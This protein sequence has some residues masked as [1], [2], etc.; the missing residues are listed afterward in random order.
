MRSANPWDWV[1]R[2][3]ESLRRHEE[4]RQETRKSLP[5]YEIIEELGRGGMAVVYR[6]WDPELGRQIAL[7][8]LQQ[9]LGA[10]P[11]MRERFLREAQMVSRL[12]H[13]HI[14]TVYDTGEWDG[15]GYLAMRLVEGTT[16]DRAE[17]DLRR[18][19][20]A[21]R[22]AAR[23][24]DHAHRQGIVH[25]DVKPSNFLVDR[26]GQV[27]VSDFGVARRIDLP[28]R[29]T[30]TGVAVGT[31]A[32]ISPEQAQGRDVDPRSDVYSLGAAMYEILCGQP[33]FSGADALK[34]MAARLSA[35]PVPPSRR[36]AGLSRA[37][38]KIVQ[39]A[40]EREPAHRYASAAD[41]ADDIQRFLDGEPIR[42]RPAPLWFRAR[43]FLVRH[44]WRLVAA[45]SLL[46]L[47]L[48]AARIFLAKPAQMK[49]SL[50]DRSRKAIEETM[51]EFSATLEREDFETAREILG[52]MR[53]LDP[54]GTAPFE[55]NLRKRELDLYKRDFTAAL[56]AG[57]FERARAILESIRRLDLNELSPL[58]QAFSLSKLET[59]KG[60]FQASMGREDWDGA[61]RILVTI[62]GLNPREAA[63][64]RRELRARQFDE[65]S[66][67][68]GEY[69]N[70][71]DVV[72]FEQIHASLSGPEFD[73]SRIRDLAWHLA[74]G[75]YLRDQHAEAVRWLAGPGAPGKHRRDLLEIRALARIRLGDLDGA[76]ADLR[77]FN[78]DRRVGESVS[79]EYLGLLLDLALRR[80][81]KDLWPEAL[82]FLD[83]AI[84]ADPD[85][86]PAFH[87]RGLIRLRAKGD[88]REALADLETAQGLQLQL[89]PHGEYAGI[90]LALV[91]DIWERHWKAEDARIRDAAWNEAIRWLT[92]VRDAGEPGLVRLELARMHR[93]LRQYP[94]ALKALE[95][96]P[97][98]PDLFLTRGQIR[99]VQ[100]NLREALQDFTEAG[101]RKPDD[102]RILHWLGACLQVMGQ[103]EESLEALR[104]AV[105]RGR[106]VPDAHL[107]IGILLNLPETAVESIAETTR[108]LEI[109]GRL[110]EDCYILRDGESGSLSHEMVVR[111]FRRDAGYTRAR[112]RYDEKDD[113]GCIS[114][115][116]M[117]IDLDPAYSKGFM[118]RALARY[119][120]KDY[121][122][123][124]EDCDKVIE[125]IQDSDDPEDK[126][127]REKA[128]RLRETCIALL[129]E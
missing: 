97:E 53:E 57:D 104:R 81:G 66:R 84:E 39:K 93:R 48:G 11:E 100:K 103:D 17:L 112:A 30:L 73:P 99:L 92:L 47:L 15:Q 121:R 24:L 91:K 22:D 34:V 3:T 1:E 18:K 43:R 54:K 87:D 85:F 49:P 21:L 41:L 63:P 32:Y 69:A 118:L 105:E 107:R 7:K 5:R 35:D 56:D 33:P 102:G 62:E 116:S 28:S 2:L 117:C 76:L 94:E 46:A 98:G 88:P 115:C 42:A 8:V 9:G 31:P 19:L 20:G 120:E 26:E 109:A 108:A 77:L 68:L 86:A 51:R 82:E 13:P 10:S 27:Y 14:V 72:A 90:A 45:G 124:I 44:G 58:Q 106:D 4:V 29:I 59:A 122:G 114:D 67:L 36:R 83:E 123:A 52:R 55:Y 74:S 12:D 38:D 50:E 6:A 113:R 71:T 25:R 110:G 129:K 70:Y 79:R 126:A 64:L 16:L 111:I 65:G 61:E 128:I 95:G 101:R 89:K 125:L 78:K 119:R 80:A 96:V 127:R 40:M 60:A 75:L 37:L 23:A